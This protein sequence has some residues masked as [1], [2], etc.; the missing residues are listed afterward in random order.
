MHLLPL[1]KT[2]SFKTISSVGAKNKMGTMAGTTVLC[3]QYPARVTN[4]LHPHLSPPFPPQSLPQRR[5]GFHKSLGPCSSMQ[6]H[7]T[8]PSS[9]LYANSP[10]T[11]QPPL[12]TTLPL[13]TAFSTT[14][15]PTP[16]PTKPFTPHPW[17]SGPAPTPA[18]CPDLSRAVWLAARLGLETPTL[19]P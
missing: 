7:W 1:D 10:P 14:P 5:L 17:L 15:H 6:E 2:F 16:T 4:T 13:P 18:S 11:N 9:P 19:P 3:I 12:N 8:F